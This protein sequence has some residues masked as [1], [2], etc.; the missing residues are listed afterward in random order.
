MNKLQD[1]NELRRDLFLSVVDRE[2]VSCIGEVLYV[3]MTIKN[4][5][6]S[7]P[8]NTSAYHIHEDGGM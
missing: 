5:M 3:I 1:L 4:L 8:R 7:S 2:E 6:A